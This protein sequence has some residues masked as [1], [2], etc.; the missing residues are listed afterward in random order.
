MISKKLAGALNA[1]TATHQ[2]CPDCDEVIGK[3]D[4]N[5][6]E[7]VALCPKCGKLSKLSELSFSQRSV[8]EILAKPPSGC[9]LISIQRGVIVRASCR[10]IIGFLFAAGIATFW[11]SITSLFVAIGLEGLYANLVGP[12]PEWMPHPALMEGK[13]V[14][15]DEP[16]GL[17]GSLFVLLFMIPFVTI[18]IGMTSFALMSLLGRV[19][20]VIDEDVSS[21][22]AGIGW[23]MWRTKFDP[24]AVSEISWKTSTFQSEGRSNN[25]IVI[26]AD[27]NVKFGGILSEESSEWMKAILREILLAP[28]LDSSTT[29]P[30]AL[31]WLAVPKQETSLLP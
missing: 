11:C 30:P 1:L 26:E 8:V 3:S 16:M 14:M 4:I 18:G 13:P 17:G 19:D 10:S 24:R 21:A 9:E 29:Y 15:N 2:R 28:K 12:I 7:G 31:A 25:V 5:I 22:G 23:L 6:A 27:R 20:V